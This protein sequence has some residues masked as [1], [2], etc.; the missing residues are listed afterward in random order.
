MENMEKELGEV[1]TMEECEL[2]GLFAD[3]ARGNSERVR[4]LESVTALYGAG[5]IADHSF[6]RIVKAIVNDDRDNA[7]V[8]VSGNL[9]DKAR[10]VLEALA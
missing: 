10:M 9:I 7:K 6:V 4:I 8:A 2:H 3:V 5:F 1:F